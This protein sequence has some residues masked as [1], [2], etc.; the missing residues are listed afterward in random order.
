MHRDCRSDI[1]IMYLLTIFY[2]VLIYRIH[3]IITQYVVQ[4]LLHSAGWRRWP[5]LVNMPDLRCQT[6]PYG[7]LSVLLPTNPVSDVL[8][9]GIKTPPGAC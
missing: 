4:N 5:R 1:S 7:L 6:Q 2:R 9:G 3:Y 8:P